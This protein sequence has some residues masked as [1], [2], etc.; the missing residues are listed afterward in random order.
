MGRPRANILVHRHYRLAAVAALVAIVQLLGVSCSDGD[1]SIASQPDE[2]TTS[3]RPTTTA[4]PESS[5]SSALARRVQNL[6]H[7]YD[8]VTRDLGRDPEA[9]SDPRNPLY[10]QLRGFVTPDSEMIGPVVNALVARG[11]RGIS[12]RAQ[13]NNDLPVERLIEGD[14]QTVSETELEVPV[15]THLNYALFNSNNQQTELVNGRAEPADATIVRAGG[16]LR[17]RRF[18]S[19]DD[20]NRCEGGQ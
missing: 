2:S 18:E 17:I 4:A 1:G 13:G 19:V 20:D 5:Q 6:L 11:V 15:C 7:S 8:E 9:A 10:D 14:I 12:Q 3:P 16:E